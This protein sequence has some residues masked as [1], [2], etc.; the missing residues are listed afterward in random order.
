MTV[1]AFITSQRAEHAVPTT[2]SCRALG[3]SGSWYYKWR[4]RP[5]TPARSRQVQ[6]E[7]AVWESFKA[8]GFTYG[9]PRVHAILRRRGRRVSR[10]GSSG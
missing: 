8:S 6:L 7:D 1:A 2:V 10:S 9:S 4:D 5:P 3:V